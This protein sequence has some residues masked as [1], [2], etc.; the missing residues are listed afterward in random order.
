MKT[1]LVPVDFS[2]ASLNAV[3]YAA[4]L[5]A[6]FGSK[7]ILL[8]IFP[9]RLVEIGISPE[10]QADILEQEETKA[11]VSFSKIEAQ[12][13]PEIRAQIEIDYQTIIGPAQEEILFASDALTPDLVVMG[14]RGGNHVAKKI[15]GSTAA[16]V[17]QH[18]NF[19]VM[20][21]PR[22]AHYRPIRHIAFATNFEDE[23]LVAIDQLL[24]FAARFGAKVHCVHIRQNGKAQDIFKQEIMHKAF[25]HDVIMHNIDFD[26]LNYTEVVE[27]LNQY[28]RKNGIDMLVML[29]HQRGLYNQLFYQRYTRRMVVQSEVPLWAFQM[30]V[31]GRMNARVESRQEA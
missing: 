5:A 22:H 25:E 19:P 16:A 8:H 1:I 2:P 27:G 30:G 6:V 18:S 20:I 23:D 26:T 10:M 28:V 17:V 24:K 7:L 14:M 11:R 12:I 4:P 31:L 9:S 15:L 3:R 13:P 29:T 21:V